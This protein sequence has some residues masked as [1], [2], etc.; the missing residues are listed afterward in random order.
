MQSTVY[1]TTWEFREADGT[2][3]RF[4]V[5]DPRLKAYA[6]SLE[7]DKSSD[8]A[9]LVTPEMIERGITTLMTHGRFLDAIDFAGMTEA[10]SV[11]RRV[12]LA[13]RAAAPRDA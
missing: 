10:E 5:G 11:L 6:A 13:M 1:P 9:N 7:A 2:T 3:R 12:Y 4:E 8:H